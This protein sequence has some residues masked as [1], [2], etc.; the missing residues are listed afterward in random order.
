VPGELYT[1]EFWQELV[2][3]VE[4]DGIVAIVR[5]LPSLRVVA[6]ESVAELCRSTG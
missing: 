2:E 4:D 6:D 3:M 1:I 5:D